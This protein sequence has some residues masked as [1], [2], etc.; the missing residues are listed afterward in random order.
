MFRFVATIWIGMTVL[1][2]LFIQREKGFVEKEKEKLSKEKEIRRESFK[3]KTNSDQ[4]EKG[5]LNESEALM[6]DDGQ[7]L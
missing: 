2:V 6:K 7:D 4:G 5:R 3:R 1:P